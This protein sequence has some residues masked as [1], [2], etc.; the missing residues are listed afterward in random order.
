MVIAFT[1]QAFLVGAVVWS[2]IAFWS[3]LQRDGGPL[4]V[5][6]HWVVHGAFL[7]G[8]LNF[9]AFLFH[10]STLGGDALN[11]YF[12]E[13]GKYYV[14]DHGQYTLVSRAAF[15]LNRL[16]ALSQVL[17]LP[18]TGVAAMSIGASRSGIES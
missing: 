16:H 14:S 10:C 9:V 2:A 1:V 13:T 5:R 6:G 3:S 11:G 17:T 8:A 18:L 7:I 15:E 4:K 12:T